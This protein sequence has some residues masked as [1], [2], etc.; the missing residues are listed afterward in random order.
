MQEVLHLTREIV[1]KRVV[2]AAGTPLK[3]AVCDPTDSN[4]TLVHD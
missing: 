1:V 2:E 3:Y 4:R